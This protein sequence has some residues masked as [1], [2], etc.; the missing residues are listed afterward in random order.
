MKLVTLAAALVL[1]LTGAA[2]AQN[3][4]V[5]RG[6]KGGDIGKCVYTF[7]KTKDG[8]KVTSRFQAT[9]PTQVRA[10][11]DPDGA[12]KVISEVQQ[13]HA[14]KLD[15]AYL[16]AGGT[17]QDMTTQMTN[18]FSPNKQRT[19]MTLSH[20]QA[21]IQG[22]SSQLP[23][24]PAYMLLSNYDCSAL[25]S[26]LYMATTHPTADGQ[27]YLI[28]PPASGRP[29]GGP[30]T[31]QAHWLAQPDASGT[32]AGKPVT[33]HHYL[34]SFGK[35]DYNLYADETN[36][37]LEADVTKLGNMIRAGFVLTTPAPA[38]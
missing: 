25:Q 28:V 4:F 33:V 16:Y 8:Y 18:G 6:A 29:G 20:V 27:Y 37:L 3:T 15:A 10:N 17:I 1:A 7:D 23:L 35:I 32:L 14:Y 34:I 36:T 13:N 19:Q 30:Q 26:L 38:Q 11:E 24:Q 2:H 9:V 31:V 12:A 22:Q 5:I 21:G